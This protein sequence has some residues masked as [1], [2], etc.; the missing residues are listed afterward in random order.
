MRKVLLGIVAVV[1]LL[2]AAPARAERLCDPAGEDC[3]EILLNLIRAERT[4]IDVAFWFMEDARYSAEIIRR[5]Q[6]GVPVRVLFDARANPGHPVNAQIV[7]QLRAAGIPI[8]N[9]VASGILHWK[10]ML[11]A[12]Q[13]QVEFSGANYS[14]DALVFTDP[15]RNYVDEAILFSDEPATV[16]SFM[17]RFDDL[18]TD[19]TSYAS[20]A[21]VTALRRS[22]GGFA[23]SPELNFPPSVSYRDRAVGAYNAEKTAIDVIMYRITDRA[24]T[25]AIIAAVQRG[26]RVRLITE[27]EEYRDAARPWHSWNVDRLYMAGVEIRHRAHAGLNHQKSVILRSQGLSIFGSSNWTSPSNQ[28]QEEHNEFTK[29]AWVFQWFTAQFERKWNNTA[30]A[31]ETQPFAPLPP[32]APV[33]L[34][35]AQGGTKL[36]QSTVISFDAGPFA[37][38]YDIY[39]GTSP[40][41]PLIASDV[42][43]G[44]NENGTPRNYQLPSL[45]TGTTYYWRVVAKTMALQGAAGPVWSFTTA[46]PVTPVSRPSMNIDTPVNGA[47]V[48]QPFLLGGWALDAGAPTGNGIDVVHVYAYPFAGGAPRFIG[49]LRVNRTRTDVAAAFGARFSPSGYEVTVLGLPPGGHRIIV[50]GHSTLTDKFEISRTVDV[51][52][53]STAMIVLDTPAAGAVVGQRFALGGWAIDPGAAAGGGVDAV[54]AYAYPIDRAG[55]AIF[56]GAAPVNI[57]R[58]DLASIFGAQF[59]RSGWSVVTSLSPGAYRLVLYAHS[60]VAGAFTA[61]VV[62]DVTVR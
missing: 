6:A 50:Y 14:P 42:P 51:T 31:P 44:P 57:A 61:V 18:W 39:L 29:K 35:P 24:H 53:A 34:S 20:Y 21:N 22:Y 2:D 11:F 10:M 30:P 15:F 3:R 54:H 33:N 25:D 49:E 1:C 9:R 40:N 45:N 23:L 8:R 56:L 52:V 60:T 41:P 5:F 55:G 7:E 37:H 48:R 59:G 27:Q 26:V 47:S 16:R 62:R 38:L 19:T 32:S 4:G 36:P 28:S 12:G 13:A 58:P 17:Q 46:G 43:L